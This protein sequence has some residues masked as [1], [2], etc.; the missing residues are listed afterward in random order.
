MFAR[1]S[2]NPKLGHDHFHFLCEFKLSIK[3]SSS[4]VIPTDMTAIAIPSDT[5]PCSNCA[6]M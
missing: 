2:P 5:C 6:N 1:S 4:V 3:I